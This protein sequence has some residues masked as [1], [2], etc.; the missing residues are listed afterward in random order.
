MSIQKEIANLITEIYKGAEVKKIDVDNFLD[1]HLPE[2][3]S[4]KGSHLYFNTAKDTIKIGFYC[5]DVE[6]VE[7]VMT[8][9]SSIENVSNGIRPLNNPVFTNAKDAVEAAKSFISNIQGSGITTQTETEEEDDPID[10]FAKLRKTIEVDG[11]E[12][13]EVDGEE[14]E[15]VDG[16][17]DEEV[18]GE[19]DEEVD[20][21]EDEE[22]GYPMI[23]IPGTDYLDLSDDERNAYFEKWQA[24]SYMYNLRAGI[25]GC[26]ADWVTYFNDTDFAPIL[27]NGQ[28]EAMA[29]NLR[30]HKAIP[31]LLNAPEEARGVMKRVWWAVPL[32]F[33]NEIASPILI[34]KN[35][36]YSL[37]T[38]NFPKDIELTLIAAWDHIDQVS[39]IPGSSGSSGF[40]DE[41][42]VNCLTLEY[43]NGEILDLF[44]LVRHDQN[45]GSYLEII[46]AI[47]ENRYETIQQSKGKPMWKEGAGGEGYIE[48]EEIIQ[49]IRPDSFKDVS[50]PDPGSFA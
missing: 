3:H 27:N 40:D 43:E 7:Q 13:E 28:V 49:L 5:R 41:E 21:E 50:R 22:M 19:E 32:C 1:I 42:N 31:I 39:F 36:I 4:A 37:Y 25:N 46:E 11:E 10:F 15:E 47:W 48:I 35:G 38:K 17:E 6:F 12:D 18:D 33:W 34:N 9:S 24:P 16:E 20:G 30:E 44:E 2:V 8:G 26:L 14:D 23:R 29:N 45:Q